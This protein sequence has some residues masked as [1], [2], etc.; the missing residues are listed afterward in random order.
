MINQTWFIEFVYFL[1]TLAD[2][3]YK[4]G[5]KKNDEESRKTIFRINKR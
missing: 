5:I 2:N 4:R 3:E 1:S